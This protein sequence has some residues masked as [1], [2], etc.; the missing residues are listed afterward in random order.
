MFSKIF[1]K[2]S[3]ICVSAVAAV[4]LIISIIIPVSDT[5]FY[6]NRMKSELYTVSESN[7]GD[8]LNNIILSQAD[9]DEKEKN[10]S[11]LISDY[12]GQLALNENRKL[13]IFD[14]DYN[15]IAPKEQSGDI[16]EK[17]ENLSNVSDEAD[18]NLC[19]LFGDFIDCAAF[20]KGGTNSYILYIRDNRT[21]LRM[22]IYHGF[23]F[24]ALGGI[25]SLAAALLVALFLT[26]R[27]AKPILK[28]T[29][30]AE[31]FQQGEL[32]ESFDDIK[33]SEFSGLADAVNHMGYVMTESIQRMNADKHR[34]EVILEH[35]NNGI[36]TFDN[37]QQLIQINSAARRILKIGNKNAKEITFDKFFKELGLEVRMAEFSY[38]EK[39]NTIEKEIKNGGG[40]IKAWFIP[41]KMDSERNAGVVCVFEDITDQFNVMSAMRK[42]V[43]DVS[44]ELKT[45][46]TV[47]S[48][49][50]ETVLNSYLDDKA[51]TAN[52][53]NIVYREAGKMT[54]LIQNLLDISKYEMNAVHRHD[55][56]FSIDDMLNSLVETFKLQA[57]KKEL[58]LKYTRMNEIPEFIGSRGDVERAVKNI[59]SNSIKYTSKGDKIN[60]FAGKLHNDIY[61]KVEDTGWGIP[62][63]KLGHLFER[64]YRVED[65]ARSR[66]KGGTGLGLSIAKEIIESYGGHIKIESEYTKYTRVTITLPIK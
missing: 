21:D 7:F 43:A 25:I 35:I 48:S 42:F 30:R 3:L 50:T 28:I 23:K 29:K 56:P 13:Y 66:D 27:I 60:I 19:S 16:R 2:F 6:F 15:Y 5:Y 65:E 63:N 64:F 61:I 37:E 18:K 38:L 55:E 10:I 45:P 32:Y 33:S 26:L 46:I 39:S 14:K 17:S 47:I 54:E 58:T 59:I 44:H 52:L 31:G 12:S 49:Y 34:V 22:L 24:F 20:A 41:F 51:M 11:N 62:E 9:I 8:N 36:M 53:L 57:E 40:Y 4:L 1:F